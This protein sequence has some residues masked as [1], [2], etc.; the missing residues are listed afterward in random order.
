MS[1]CCLHCFQVDSKQ[2]LTFK[3]VGSLTY[4]QVCSCRQVPVGLPCCVW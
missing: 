3:C 1:L 4:R 2:V